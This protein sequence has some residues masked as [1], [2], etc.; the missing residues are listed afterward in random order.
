MCIRDSLLLGFSL[1]ILG[2]GDDL[3]KGL[4]AVIDL[5]SSVTIRLKFFKDGA[6][7]FASVRWEDSIFV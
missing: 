2:I 6:K 4:H 1:L 5:L 7:L 3:I